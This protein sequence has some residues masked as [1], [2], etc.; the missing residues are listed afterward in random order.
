M[1]D[2]QRGKQRQGALVQLFGFVILPITL[3]LLVVSFGSVYIHQS[4]MRNLV[5]ERDQRAARTSANAIGEDLD[6]QITI[7]RE[8]ARELGEGGNI[9]AVFATYQLLM[10][11]FDTRLAVFSPDAEPL[12][13]NGNR[14]FW[15]QLT[16]EESS[17]LDRGVS[18]ASPEM[19]FSEPT[20]SVSEETYFI[21]GAEAL[22]ERG[23]VIVSA[24][25][26]DGT[27]ERQ[28]DDLIAEDDL[29]IYLF[30]PELDLLYAT[31]SGSTA[32]LAQG[33]S[34]QKLAQGQGSGSFGYEKEGQQI[35]AAYSVVEPLGWILVIEEPWEALLNPLLTY[36]EL[37]P[38]VLVPLVVLAVGITWFAIRQ[39]VAPL[40]ALEARSAAMTQGDY[41][42][43]Q[44]DVGGIAEI[45]RLQQTLIYLAQKVQSAQQSLRSYVGA[46]TKG[47]EEERMRLAHELHD[48]TI[49][50]LIALNQ[51]VQM[52]QLPS[53]DKPVEEVLAEVEQMVE[54]TIE[55]LRRFTRDLRPLY[56]EDLGLPAA[57]EMLA[58]ETARDIGVLVEYLQTGRAQR[59]NPEEELAIYRIT[60]EALNNSIQHAGASKIQIH[61]RFSQD[62]V[63]VTISDDG[64]GFEVPE[65]L[66]EFARQGHFGL[67]GIY[68]RAEL[69]NA[70]A[71][72]SSTP[73]KGTKV[74]LT[75]SES[76][77]S[78]DD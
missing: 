72:I 21:I 45:A 54:Q 4:A 44:E 59:L 47:Q 55:G 77:S 74:G 16:A 24:F 65:S 60:Q 67:L 68:E 63:K 34:A 40:R 22:P 53:K 30:S 29:S 48:D 3:L 39:L 70:H 14:E 15:G 61:L 58:Q 42:A 31:K 43:V 57:L 51:R 56:L 49:Q 75:H 28:L 18:G 19:A 38:L 2:S 71:K 10:T 17:V 76:R 9:E 5:G 64:K 69:I 23:L 37:G 13:L 35:V 1:S 46:I 8:V 11:E 50:A 41:E 26:V 7:A 52:A 78:A 32:D 25:S 33:V 6:H 62:A 36:T 20:Y 12:A 27:I 66:A 73:G